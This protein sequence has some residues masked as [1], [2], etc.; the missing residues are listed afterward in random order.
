MVLNDLKEQKET[1]SDSIKK[2]VKKL[3]DEG[4][5]VY[6]ILFDEITNIYKA[7]KSLENYDTFHGIK[8]L[9]ELYQENYPDNQNTKII[10]SILDT[11][12]SYGD[13]ESKLRDIDTMYGNSIEE[14]YDNI[15]YREFYIIKN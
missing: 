6:T 5:E 9:C 8:R 13:N 11:I 14:I 12:T 2:K 3:D 1:P 7:N 4:N 15:E 10:S